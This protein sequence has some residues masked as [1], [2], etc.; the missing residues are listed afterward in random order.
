M[1]KSYDRFGENILAKI[2]R[3]GRTEEWDK[4]G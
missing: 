2:V 1:K 4:T 3:F